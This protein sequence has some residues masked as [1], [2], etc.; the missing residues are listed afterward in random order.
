M[1]GSYTKFEFMAAI[2]MKMRKELP[3]SFLLEIGRCF[4]YASLETKDS[5]HEIPI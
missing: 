4:N 3:L 5:H 1:R 2:L